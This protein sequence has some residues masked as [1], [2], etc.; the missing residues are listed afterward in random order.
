MKPAHATAQMAIF[1]KAEWKEYQAHA[2]QPAVVVIDRL[3]GCGDSLESAWAEV[4][5]SIPERWQSVAD[6]LV[7]TASGW[8]PEEIKKNRDAARDVAELTKDIADHAEI[9]AAMLRKRAALQV[10]GDIGLPEDSN[11]VDLMARAAELGEHHEPHTRGGLGVQF[12]TVVLPK[13]RFLRSQFGWEYWP[14]TADLIEAL[15]EAQIGFT[16]RAADFRTAAAMVVNQASTRDFMRALDA[17]VAELDGDLGPAWHSL[18]H[19][20]FAALCN[21][22]LGLDGEIE[23]SAVKTYRAQERKRRMR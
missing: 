21:A 8:S 19:D 20:T 13:L 17:A 15:G 4:L 3:L 14:N 11:L 18:S 22:A 1:L 12:K 5:Q 2:M 16:P 23:V 6:C 7:I 10:R 9:L